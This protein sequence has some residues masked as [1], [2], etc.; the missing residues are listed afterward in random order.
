MFG[1]RISCTVT[2]QKEIGRGCDSQLVSNG[3]KDITSREAGGDRQLI[4]S[5]E[6]RREPGSEG[7]IIMHRNETHD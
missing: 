2:Q 1:S 7:G 5:K 4:Q 6:M 3:T